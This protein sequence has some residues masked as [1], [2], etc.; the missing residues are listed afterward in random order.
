MRDLNDLAYFAAVVRHGGFAAAGRVLGVPKSTLSR[1]I[2]LLEDALGVRLLERST[3]RF[4][5][6]EVGQDYLRHCDALVAEAE[7]ADEVAIRRKAEPQGLVRI[8]CPIG[9]TSTLADALPAFLKHYPKVRI[10]VLS[11][12]RPVDLIR[13]GVD[14]AVRVRRN[15][16]ADPTLT[17]RVLGRGRSLLVASPELIARHG[18]P[19]TPDDL[20]DMPTIAHTEEPGEAT[21]R[22]HASDGSMHL[23][24]HHPRLSSDDFPVL[25]QGA[26]EG[27]GVTD[28]PEQIARDH[29]AQGRL[30]HLLPGFHTG[31]GTI[32]IVFT[33]RRGMLPAVRATIDLLA[34]L[35]MP[36]VAA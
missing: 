2:A 16:D 20:A 1:R 4:R 6:T 7:A 14:V 8:G 5:V 32:H 13:E 35:L 10:Q 12:N 28:L 9:F 24:H 29:I 22:L 11:S 25:L 15:M 36:A 19:T 3:R 26:L 33:S 23:V 21:W 27:V 30:V 34:G 17:M 18:L 31:E